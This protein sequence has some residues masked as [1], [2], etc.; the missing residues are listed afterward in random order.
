MK[1]T[2]EKFSLGVTRSAA[3]QD[4]ESIRQDDHDRQPKGL[5][6]DEQLQ[7]DLAAIREME[8][9]ELMAKESED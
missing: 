5:T 1:H 7:R 9:K 2:N 3:P 8:N 4:E 6:E